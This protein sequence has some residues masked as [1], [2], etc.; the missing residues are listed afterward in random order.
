MQHAVWRVPI[1]DEYPK[2][3]NSLVVVWNVEQASI[4]TKKSSK[5]Q[6]MELP[7]PQAEF[8]LMTLVIKLG[9]TSLDRLLYINPY[10]ANVEKNGELLIMPAD[11]NWDLTRRL[12][13]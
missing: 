1:Q 9:N 12:K 13:C 7:K 6:G 5:E 2:K 3:L 11:G 4:C 8:K 10:P